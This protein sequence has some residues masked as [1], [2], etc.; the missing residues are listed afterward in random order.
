[1]RSL[2][3]RILRLGLED[4][5]SLVGLIRGEEAKARFLDR[6]SMLLYLSVSREESFGKAAAEALGAGIPVAATRWD[7]LPEVV[8]RCGRL[9]PL[10]ECSRS[11]GLDAEAEAVADA[12]AD[13]LDRP[14]SAAS[15][16]AQAARFRG[17]AAADSYLA[18]LRTAVRERAAVPRP[19]ISA[20]EPLAP[21]EGLLARVALL[22]ADTWGTAFDRYR[23]EVDDIRR[24]WKGA[25]SRESRGG[26]F[27]AFLLAAT[28]RPVAQFLAGRNCARWMDASDPI[29]I[30][31][32]S[33]D[34]EGDRLRR[35]FAAPASR[36]SKAQCLFDYAAAGR[37]DLLAE[38]LNALRGSGDA[39]EAVAYLAVE[40]EIMEGR[41]A[42]AWDLFRK[43]TPPDQ[44][45]EADGPKLR[46][47]ARL[48]R[49]WNRPESA[50]PWLRSWLER[51]PDAPTAGP[52]WL[53][54][55]TLAAAT[56]EYDAEAM[57]AC[58][59][60]S[61]LLGPVEPVRALSERL[62]LR[63]LERWVNHV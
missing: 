52:L 56:G 48:G 45:N 35:M 18:E 46:Q 47:L 24:A 13:L 39:S 60:A 28:D 37:A 12:I 21:R 2:R 58:G 55:A 40:L 50:L 59:R 34:T 27:R 42:A 16:K 57:N 1:V 4:R 14:P 63:S 29:P 15:C 10:A 8:G 53:D 9:I 54:L 3:A 25:P 22:A 43:E 6:A 31:K 7:G 62:G 36:H 38:G 32:V 33:G 49:A 61:E 44:T 20:A 23:E 5:V 30:P 19:P 51:Y 26:R 17:D 11:G 41:Y